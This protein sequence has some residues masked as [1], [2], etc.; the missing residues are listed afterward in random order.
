MIT[1]EMTISEIISSYPQTIHV[2]KSFGLE[3]T[4]C[5]IADYEDV[6]HGAGVHNVDIKKLIKALN[7]AIKTGS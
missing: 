5:Q 7:Q 2:F 1:R 4:S 3:C 6:E